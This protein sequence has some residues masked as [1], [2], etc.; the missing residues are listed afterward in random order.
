MEHIRF[1]ILNFD[2]MKYWQKYSRR[3][4][5]EAE[6]AAYLERQVRLRSI[7]AAHPEVLQLHESQWPQELQDQLGPRPKATGRRGR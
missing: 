4:F 6:G 5:T 7:L 2:S 1:Q 3:S